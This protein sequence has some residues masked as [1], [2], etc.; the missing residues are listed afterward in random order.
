MT[1]SLTSQGILSTLVGSLL[2][3]NSILKRVLQAR[4]GLTYKVFA[5]INE[6]DTEEMFY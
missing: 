3:L 2:K 4:S 1:I 5:S 6:R